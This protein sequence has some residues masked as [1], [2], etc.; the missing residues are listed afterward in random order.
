MPGTIHVGLMSG[1]DAAR[2]HSRD[3][4]NRPHDDYMRLDTSMVRASGFNGLHLRERERDRERERERERQRE[5]GMEAGR[6]PAS[7]CSL[8]PSGWLSRNLI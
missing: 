1:R 3:L 5:G 6:E 7:D 4:T 8:P 2:I